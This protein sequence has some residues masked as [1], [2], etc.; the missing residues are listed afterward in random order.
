MIR[1]CAQIL[2]SALLHWSSWVFLVFIM[3]LCNYVC[4]ED[5]NHVGTRKNLAHNSRVKTTGKEQVSVLE[6]CW[7]ETFPLVS[8]QVLLVWTFCVISP[9][10]VPGEG[11]SHF[12]RGPRFLTQKDRR[13]TESRVAIQVLDVSSCLQTAPERSL[14]IAYVSFALGWAVLW[15]RKRPMLV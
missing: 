12:C 13:D 1:I 6:W 5:R 4:G 8:A 7:S 11:Y 3:F 10:S 9:F 15:G 2:V 14:P